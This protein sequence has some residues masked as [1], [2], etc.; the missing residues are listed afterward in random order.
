MP[1]GSATESFGIFGALGILVF[2]TV[3]YF[4]RSRAK[5]SLIHTKVFQQ[6]C[7]LLALCYI[8]FLFLKY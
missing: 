4:G 3:V 6:G 8:Y 7:E 2:V 1:A 5:N